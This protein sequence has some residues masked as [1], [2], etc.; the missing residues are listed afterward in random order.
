MWFLVVVARIGR[1]G[2]LIALTFERTR[3]AAFGGFRQETRIGLWIQDIRI[4]PYHIKGIVVL[5]RELRVRPAGLNDRQA[6]F[7]R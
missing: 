4:V 1:D 2:L 5:K 3:S 7:K 6:R